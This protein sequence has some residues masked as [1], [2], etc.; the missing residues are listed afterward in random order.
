MTAPISEI[1]Q[2]NI[3]RDSV[4][5]SRAGFGTMLILGPNANFHGRVQYF[6]DLASVGDALL[7][8]SD[9]A[10]YA[11]AQAAF[12]QN[13]RVERVAIG[14]RSAA[15]TVTDNAGTFTAGSISAV[16]NGE[17]K[18]QVF[19]TDKDTTLTAF[20]VK[21][22]AAAGILSAV[23]SNVGHTIIITPDAGETVGLTL[24]LS[25]VTGT[26]AVSSYS[27][28]ALDDA[29]D[30]LDACLEETTDFY[31]VILADRTEAQVLKVAAWAEA[32]EMKVF[33]TAS[34]D[35]DIVDETVAEDT[36][37]LAATFKNNSYLKTALIYSSNAA[38]EYPDAALLGRILPYDPGSYTACF[39]TLSGVSIDNLTATQRAN[40]FAKFVNVYEYV[41]GV[42]ILRQGTVS[43]NEYLD[44][45]IF[46]DWLEARCTE[47]VYQILV[48]NLK[49]PYT[50][51]G[52]NSVYNALTQPLQA[53][54]NAGGISPTE[55]DSQKAQIGGFYITV[56]R[57]EDIPTVDK[58]ARVLNN[59]KFTAFL[60][61]AIHKV[62]I[63]GTVTL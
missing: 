5:I 12:S 49:V 14:H 37:S 40:A 7:T 21:L 2:V 54:Q 63:A 33:V 26:L 43:G 3:T 41:G 59:V 46:I 9:A 45:M 17:T 6:T 4:N 55:Y 18:T 61:G 15:V 8:G 16:I 44:V 13:P 35:P 32:A 50:S 31:G 10:E 52:I 22:A 29:D 25:A 19:D 28:S 36:D 48:S 24:D 30:D 23:Y 34:N 11:A 1:V 58:T 27:A 53:G 39:K 42:N 47:A 56:P 60:S 38:T 20:A 51:A 57:L 62:V